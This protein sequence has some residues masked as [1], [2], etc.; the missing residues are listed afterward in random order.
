MKNLL[1]AL[2]TIFLLG[3]CSLEKAQEITPE[4]N[5]IDGKWNLAKIV[6]GFRPPDGIPEFKPTYVEIL[7]FS[8]TKKTFSRTKDG[9]IVE[10]S[11]FKITDLA[12]F[13]VNTKRAAIVFEKDNTYSFYSFSENPNYLILNQKAPIGATLADGNIFFYEKMQ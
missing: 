4:M 12:E 3:N 5:K 8:S 10:S 9:Q 7:E 13:G 11:N 1:L 2:T 6:V